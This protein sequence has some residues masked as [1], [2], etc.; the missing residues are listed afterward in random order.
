MRNILVSINC[1][2][3]NHEKYIGE[4]LESFMMQKTN[5][6]FEIIVSDDFSTDNTVE[7]VKKFQ[8]KYPNKIRLI[9]GKKNIG[10]R[11]NGM[12]AH[13]NSLGKY[14]AICEGD[15]YWT[16]CNKLQ[17]Q[18]NYMEKNRDCSMVFHNAEKINDKTKKSEGFMINKNLKSKKILIKDFFELQFIPT[19]SILYKKELKDNMPSWYMDA[20]TGD[21]PFNL[22]LIANS[23]AYY[24]NDIM[25]VYRVG[26]S[27]S[28]MGK[29]K[30]RSN[31][32]D[33]QINHSQGYL[34]ILKN[35]NEF[36]NFK[37]D[38]V[39]K[40]EIKNREFEILIAKGDL[41]TIKS[42]KYKENYKKMS[43]KSKLKTFIISINPRLFDILGKIRG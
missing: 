38:D 41:R 25:S 22:I 6:D 35:F 11:Q 19:A 26:N 43:I 34:D 40:E 10:A 31:N 42:G 3:Y 32:L 7:V 24:M 27:Q 23:Y 39:I 29:W 30:L 33:F 12:R 9:E 14:V 18:I 20:I 16:D 36:S 4:A 15:D 2:T 21:L 8:K 37:Y 28:M 17:K 13:N 1:I 5:F